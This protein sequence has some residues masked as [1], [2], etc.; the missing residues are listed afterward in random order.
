MR[1]HRPLAAA[2]A[3]AGL[4]VTG[5]V[6]CTADDRVGG[7]FDT[8]VDPADCGV[9]A[10]AAAEGPVEIVFWHTMVQS[11][12]DW[13]EATTKKF[14]ESQRKVHVTLRQQPNYQD[15]FTKYKAGL[16]SHDLPDLVQME[17]TVVQQVIDSRSTIPVQACIEATDYPLDDYLP[18][19]LAYYESGGVQRAMPWAIS[20]PVLFLNKAAFRKAGLDPDKP[21]RTLAEVR[22]VS[23][24]IVAKGGAKYGIALK[25]APY[26]FEFLLAKS[27]GEYV[28]HGN[29]RR[30]RGEHANLTSPQSLAILRWWHDM[31]ADGLALDTGAESSNID[32]LLALANE[33]EGAAMTMEASSAI[34]PIASVLASGAFPGVDPGTAPLPA[35]TTG[36]GVPV[37]DGA[38]W[39]PSASSPAKRAAAWTF[40]RFLN[41]GEQ[42]A[43]MAV[44]GG[45][46]PAVRSATE[47]PALVAQWKE[48]PMFRTG[49]DQLLAGKL[50][51]ANVGTLVGDYQALRNA[52]RD[53]LIRMLRNGVDPAE[54]AD[55]AKAEADIAI[56]E[57]NDRVG[58]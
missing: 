8:T 23:E 16:A 31:V 19:A 14:N 11:S 37:G 26:I 24:E 10:L 51:D 55:R 28:D 47:V 18:R 15:L 57:Y 17:E 44:A 36:G 22:K 54:A 38:L 40:I 58:A 29:G 56:Q 1:R 32:H 2:L 41:E 6:G 48:Q 50:S 39:I 5:L 34:G 27:G 25:P 33:T 7:T 45:Y 4:L 49:Y 42:Q 35:L 52:V 9:D 12:L 21:P 30:S 3:A 13:L 53:A 46:V 20:N 43:S